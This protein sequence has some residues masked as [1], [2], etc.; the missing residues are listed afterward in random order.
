MPCFPPTL[1]FEFSFLPLTT[2]VSIPQL[3]LLQHSQAITPWQEYLK[4]FF[5]VGNYKRLTQHKFSQLVSSVFTGNVLYSPSKNKKT[6]NTIFSWRF[7]LMPHHQQLS[8]YKPKNHPNWDNKQNS[9][10][11]IPSVTNPG[12]QRGQQVT[13]WYINKEQL[14]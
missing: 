3:S 5:N 7:R 12:S 8:H 6:N 4:H 14:T 11:H 2:L 1:I 13:C 10:T 9:F